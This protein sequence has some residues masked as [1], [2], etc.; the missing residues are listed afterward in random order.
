MPRSPAKTDA[1]KLKPKATAG[2]TI[3]GKAPR[4]LTGAALEKERLQ[5]RA[6]HE[7]F[8]QFSKPAPGIAKLE[9]DKGLTH[10]LSE[11]PQISGVLARTFSPGRFADA[12]SRSLVSD[13]VGFAL[14]INEDGKAAAI[15]KNGYARTAADGDVKWNADTRM[16]IASASKFFSAVALVKLL[17]QHG[18]SFDRRVRD[19]LP[20]YWSI[21]QKAYS[22]TFN[23]ILT[24]KGGLWVGAC[25]YADVKREVAVATSGIGEGWHY[26]NSNYALMR[27]LIP[28]I[29]GDLRRDIDYG[30]VFGP[31]GISN[32]S[33]WDTLTRKYFNDYLQNNI[34]IPSGVAFASLKS[35][36]SLWNVP[37]FSSMKPYTN[38]SIGYGYPPVSS[39]THG[40][41]IAED[42][43][44]CAGA[45]GWHVSCDEML[46]VANKVRRGGGIISR[47]TLNQM[48]RLGYGFFGRHQNGTVTINY[49][50]GIWSGS[51]VSEWSYLG[52][53]G[54]RY[55]IAVLTNNARD[56]GG[57][58]LGLLRDRVHAAYDASLR[59]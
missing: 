41:D 48:F 33:A 4:V 10:G 14:Q 28:I 31:L 25:E 15:R 36:K 3:A 37:P 7:M 17:Y 1:S 23:N 34:W 47:R 56:S 40:V 42:L 50:D 18:I 44:G 57:R 21:G 24:H 49:H 52:F 54:S 51:D 59:A 43:T 30:K 46:R 19:F 32:D 20:S 9:I 26:A 35:T 6:S 12:L 27:V 22:L 16:H 29:N 5:S 39:S 45:V 13:G 11:T 38:A 8:V 53:I 58:S 55:E 2:R